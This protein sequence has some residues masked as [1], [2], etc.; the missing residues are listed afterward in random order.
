[1]N[2]FLAERLSHSSYGLVG[3]CIAMAAILQRG[4]GCAMAQQDSVDLVCWNSE[5]GDSYLVQV[6]SCQES[7]QHK[8][9]LYFQMGLGG[10]KD[11]NGIRRKRMPTRNDFDILALVATEQRTCFFM[12]VV[13][14]NQ[15]KITKQPSFFDNP[16]IESESWQKTLE[17]LNDY[18]KSQ[19]MHNH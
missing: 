16:E 3:E 14:I 8:N 10:T 7:R 19:T 2:R 15:I 9:R 13:G 1:M 12:P 5:N 6:R 18:P 17:V 4:W 11:V